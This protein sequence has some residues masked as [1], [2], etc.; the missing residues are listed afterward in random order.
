MLELRKLS[1]PLPYDA[2]SSVLN[3]AFQERLDA[4][5]NFAC[6]SFSGDDLKN[7]LSPDAVVF[8]AYMDDEIV[9]MNV[10]NSIRTKLGIKF[11]TAEYDGVVSQAKHK[12]IGR[13]L[14]RERIKEAKNLGLDFIISDTAVGAESA[15]EYHK[16]MGYK[17]YGH[18]HYPGRTYDSVNYILPLTLKGQLLASWIGR[19]ILGIL[20][21]KKYK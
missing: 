9:A 15:M 11:A 10:L 14:S 1:H 6:A 20:F 7:H 2:L 4:G 19:R 13:V 8:V 18:S 5:L 17:V 3:D 21:A 12:G 16:K